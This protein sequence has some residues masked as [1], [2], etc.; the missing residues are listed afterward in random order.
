VLRLLKVAAGLAALGAAAAAPAQSMSQA[1][2]IYR[3][4]QAECAE[5]Y[6]LRVARNCDQHCLAAAESRQVSCL[7]PA[8]RRY[9]RILRRELRL[10]D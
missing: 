2:L 9:Q 10:R 1:I 6:R 7:A 8:E 3:A 4:A 5:E